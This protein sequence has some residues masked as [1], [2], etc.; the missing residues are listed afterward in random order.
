MLPSLRLSPNETCDLLMPVPRCICTAVFHALKPLIERKIMLKEHHVR[1]YRSEENLAREGQLAYKIATVAADPCT[2][3]RRS[4]RW[5]PAG[6][7]P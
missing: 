1:V 6:T 7:R 2:T 5:N 4:K 3:T